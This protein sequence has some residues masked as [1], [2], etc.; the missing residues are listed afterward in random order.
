MNRSATQA[1][2]ELGAS[3]EIDDWEI[4]IAAILE[5]AVELSRV[6]RSSLAAR[7]LALG[8][9]VGAD[10]PSVDN[11]RSRLAM[12]LAARIGDLAT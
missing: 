2:V 5:E 3:P 12:R 11:E 7:I 4:L 8:G 9:Y 1:F 6:E 10:A